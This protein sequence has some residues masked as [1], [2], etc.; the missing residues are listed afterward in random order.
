[1]REKEL[2]KKGIETITKL[3]KM[4]RVETKKISY[5]DAK[6]GKIDINEFRNAI[7]SLLEADDYLYKKAPNHYLNEDEAKEFCKL[8]IKS[9]NSLNKLLSNFGYHYEKKELNKNA[10]YIVSSK[11]LFRKLKNKGLYVVSTDGFLDIEDYK[12]IIKD[13]KALLG[14]KK[15]I[16]IT[17]KNIEKFI[18]KINPEKIYFVVSDEDDLKVYRRAKELY[19]AEKV[20][21]DDIE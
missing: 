5:K 21:I 13:E 1:M 7:Y 10:L 15:K 20:D 3:K 2:I 12:S 4:K 11:K 9:I 8:I 17:K 6:P 14:I 16:E 18:K 19:N